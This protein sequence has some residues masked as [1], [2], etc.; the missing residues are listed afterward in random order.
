MVSFERAGETQKYS[1]SDERYYSEKY[2]F[3]FA[4]VATESFSPECQSLQ[5]I[6][7][8]HKESSGWSTRDM[9]YIQL[10]EMVM[11]ESL[12]WK[13]VHKQKTR[14]DK[15]AWATHLYSVAIAGASTGESPAQ[16]I[17]RLLHDAIEDTKEN[18][19]GYQIT[20]EMLFSLFG[21]YDSKIAHTVQLL[22]KLK[23]NYQDRDNALETHKRLYEL[24]QYDPESIAIKLDDRIHY[25]ETSGKMG[26][27]KVQS[28]ATETMKYYWPLAIGFGWHHKAQI[29]SDACLDKLMKNTRASGFKYT[30]KEYDIAL[31]LLEEEAQSF[32]KANN[33]IG[34]KTRRPTKADAYMITKGQVAKFSSAW[35]PAFMTIIADEKASH[36]AYSSEG[37]F[38]HVSYPFVKQL[39][40]KNLITQQEYNNFLE[41]M[42]TGVERTMHIDIEIRG[43]P[44]RLRFATASD[45]AKWLS[46][47]SD[48]TSKDHRRAILGAFAIQ[49]SEEFKKMFEYY[50]RAGVSGYKLL[51]NIKDCLIRGTTTVLIEGGGEVVLPSHSTALDLA[52]AHGDSDTYANVHTIF[53]QSS[54]GEWKSERFGAEVVMG[55]RY[56]IEYDAPSP[57]LTVFSLDDV[58]TQ[59]GRD[60][61][62][63]YIK[64]QMANGSTD[65]E[66]HI[67][68]A[69]N[70]GRKKIERLYATYAKTSGAE[71]KLAVDIEKAHMLFEHLPVSKYAKNIKN[72]RLISL[73]IKTALGEIPIDS[74][75]SSLVWDVVKELYKQQHELREVI[76]TVS[77][78]TGVLSKIT[79]KI[80]KMGIN[81]HSLHTDINYTVDFKTGETKG[82]TISIWMTPR[83]YEIYHRKIEQE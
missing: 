11:L 68:N 64:S 42:T 31:E 58:H 29:L 54:D 69:I 63:H 40:R 79:E 38:D 20:E 75:Q 61:I 62:L 81:I 57:T 41:Q 80:A 47:I 72:K 19:N 18:E 78:G 43:V 83:E 5:A 28:K 32:S 21:G 13:I 66:T 60:Q 1:F 52:L 70:Y 12:E 15:K 34:S 77:D 49:K 16:I 14:F 27:R 59:H 39:L 35:I 44:V 56:K 71:E 65:R 2:R 46:S 9:R 76:I 8:E 30:T 25:F 6:L 53:I 51:Q 50:T 37:I 22:S 33:Q 82:A 36:L 48:I 73:L 23:T 17:K 74:G 24:V 4:P 26:A 55:A 3:D 67:Q 45:E 10:A 7:Y